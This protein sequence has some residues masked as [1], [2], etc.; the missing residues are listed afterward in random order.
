MTVANQKIAVRQ[1]NYRALSFLCYLVLLTSYLKAQHYIPM[2]PSILNKNFAGY[3]P[4]SGKVQLLLGVSLFYLYKNGE[5]KKNMDSSLVLAQ[6][7]LTISKNLHYT[8]GQD[9]AEFMTGMVY[10]KNN[11]IDKLVRLFAECSPGIRIRIMLE[12]VKYNAYFKTATK[13]ELDTAL[14]YTQQS[15]ILCDSIHSNKLRS[16]ALLQFANVYYRLGEISK[17]RE[18]YLQAAA[19]AKKSGYLESEAEMFCQMSTYVKLSKDQA[20]IKEMEQYGEKLLSA[21]HLL[22]DSN[23][24]FTIQNLLVTGYD[25]LS[26]FHFYKGQLNTAL[27][28]SL[29]IAKILEKEGNPYNV[30]LPYQTIAKIYYEL[31]DMQHSI[32]YAKMAYVIVSRK[33]DILNATAL[34]TLTRAH[35]A[36]QQPEKALAFLNEVTRSGE[37][38]DFWSRRII[39]ESYGNCY[40]AMGQYSKAEKYYLYGLNERAETDMETLFVMC[41]P[42]AK[43]YIQTR[44]YDKARFYLNTLL[45]KGTE[46]V[47]LFIKRDAHFMLFKADSATGNFI[48]SIKHLHQYKALNDSIF[49]EKRNAQFDELMLQYE[50]DKKDKDLK[51]K[52]QELQLLTKKSELQEADLKSA[53]FSRNVFIGA[54]F[55]LFVMLGMVYNRYRFKQKTNLLLQQKQEEINSNNQHLQHLNEQQ[56]KLLTEKE[57]LVKEIHHRVKNNLQMIISLLNAQSEFLDNPTAVHAIQESRERMQAIALIHK[58]LYEPDSSALIN[59]ESYIHE[60]VGYIET[61]F[62]DSQKIS[63]TSV[64]D[65]ISLDV[66]QA[67]PVGLILN[68]AITNAVKY[69]FQPSQQGKVSIL[70]KRLNR[71]DIVLKISD[72]GKGLPANFNSS[73]SNSLGIQLMQLF[74]EQLDG[75]ISFNNKDG[76]E[77][78][79]TFKQSDTGDKLN[80][81]LKMQTADGENIN[82]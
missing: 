8:N 46:T 1:N 55:I 38:N 65:D 79:V 26:Y 25:Q 69:A 67:V 80:S 17:G 42:L 76:V 81:L 82:S 27:G 57:W 71:Q 68:E 41:T 2:P 75:D 63:F 33:G 28:Y 74:A 7:A 44:Q 31:G 50:T 64:I 32:D 6:E 77:I 3:K 62:K 73:E 54:I 70:M 15:L 48:T 29:D 19:E 35:I 10:I 60:M 24:I 23:D 13:K 59:M 72:T 18:Y 9:E 36:L 4:D 45:G 34:K 12:K 16:Q 58:K 14:S 66:S 49:N 53:R 78:V 21:Y 40:F 22:K 56:Q 20:L 47:P 52:E 5:A 11:E 61:S 37:Y 43:L 39:A 51:M 30:E